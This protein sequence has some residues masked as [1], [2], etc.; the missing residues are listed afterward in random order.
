MAESR[1]AREDLHM[2]EANA[3]SASGFSMSGTI[4]V[5]IDIGTISSGIAYARFNPEDPTTPR[6]YIHN[7]TLFRLSGSRVDTKILAS[8]YNEELK[9]GEDC[10]L[11]WFKMS[12]LRDTDLPSDV[13]NSRMFTEL[14]TL[15]ENLGVSAVTATAD[16]LRLLWSDFR[17]S[18]NCSVY[19][20]SYSLVVTV[21]AFW[22][23]YARQMMLEAIHEANLCS[24]EVS[25]AASIPDIEAA[26]IALVLDL[27]TPRDGVSPILCD[28][29]V[30]IVCE[31][32][33][34]TTESVTYAISSIRPLQMEQVTQGSCTFAGGALI[35][36]TFMQL[37]E[38]KLAK[39]C[40]SFA[41][42]EDLPKLIYH[43][44]ERDIK[45][46]F[47]GD[48]REW[49]IPVYDKYGTSQTISFS[50]F[51]LALV[52]DPVVD[53]IVNIV[54]SQVIKSGMR[55]AQHVI[56]TGG[57]GR[58]PYVQ[59][60]IK[61]AVLELLPSTTI[62]CPSDDQGCT[63]VA[64]GAVLRGLQINGSRASVFDW[65]RPHSTSDSTAP[66]PTAPDNTDTGE[67]PTFAEFCRYAWPNAVEYERSIDDSPKDET[68]E[69][70]DATVANKGPVISSLSSP[71]ALQDAKAIR[72]KII[73]TKRRK[74]GSLPD[75][76]YIEWIKKRK[77]YVEEEE[78]EDEHW[79][80]LD[81]VF[82]VGL[83]SHNYHA[84]DSA[85]VTSHIVDVSY[86]IAL[87]PGIKWLVYGDATLPTVGKTQRLLPL[88]AISTG[89]RDSYANNIV[90]VCSETIY[91]LQQKPVCTITWPSTGPKT[92]IMLDFK[93]DGFHM[94][95]SALHLVRNL[96]GAS[97]QYDLYA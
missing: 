5:G 65:V 57:F 10:F 42:G 9:D 83:A 11:R 26:S 30:A 48:R 28:G 62:H 52:F 97:I 12:L 45:S 18:L 70:Q 76:D 93:W 59:T 44:W 23:F 85:Y 73:P 8:V 56:I 81:T 77:K 72:V 54:R 34:F 79:D 87:H 32:G 22:P 29:D 46:S 95:V 89:D 20:F 27:S 51:E 37:L 75:A 74:A 15:R 25:I 49:T 67:A 94:E 78:E 92:D 53:K 47:C 91:D 90:R 66:V 58:S 3:S 43:H 6:C 55:K 68:G 71:G 84:K 80:Y 1:D 69:E 63:A 31:C 39:S 13:R 82:R 24:R 21:P 4:V 86:G 2:H 16:Y 96:N 19:D 88:E 41:Y 60:R 64:R 17:E 14:T 7:A 36:D 38:A 61:Q 40:P 33:G 50:A 35:D